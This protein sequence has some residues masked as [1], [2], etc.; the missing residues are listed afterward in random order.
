MLLHKDRS[1]PL[2]AG[3]PWD[4]N[5]AFGLCCGYP[6]TGW[7][8][9]GASGPGASAGRAPART[10]RRAAAHRH[11]R[12][13]AAPAARRTPHPAGQS[14]G[15]AISP[16]G[17]RFMICAEPER[18]IVDPT[19]GLSPWYRW[20]VVRRRRRLHCSPSSAY[21]GCMPSLKVLV[22]PPRLC[23]GLPAP[24]HPPQAHVV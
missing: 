15:S 9:Q 1:A 22:S 4:Y 24:W 13:S 7:D 8:K 17:W 12:G 2:A 3:P 20:A 10:S 16:E 14:G 21:A 18:C 23:T 6:M 5:E 19:D 11:D